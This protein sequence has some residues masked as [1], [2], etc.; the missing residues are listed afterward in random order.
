MYNEKKR[1]YLETRE[2]LR[3]YE[4]ALTI[5]NWDTETE[6]PIG[7]LEKRG[8]VI[9]VLSSMYNDL[10]F[11]EEYIDAVN[12]LYENSNESDELFKR[13]ILKVKKNLD[14]TLKLP[15]ELI[16][17]A[18]I[19][20]AKAGPAWV[21]AKV[22]NNF[23]LFEPHLTKIVDLQRRMIKYLETEE[24][25]G[26]D[27]LLD[28]YEEGMTTK[29]YDEFFNLLKKELVPLIKEISNTPY[30]H[31][32]EF[33]KKIYPVDKQKEFAKYIAS[34][35]CFDYTRGLD[36]ESEHPFTSGNS[37]FD[38]RLTNHYYEDYFI[39]SIFS[40][41]HELGHATFEQQVGEE[42]DDTLLGGCSAM[43]LHES[44]SRF[45]ENIVGR[46]YEF[47]SKHYGKL[48]EVFKEQLEDV[49][50]DTFYH[51]VNK[52]ECSLIRTEADEL[53]Y[54]LH[55]MIRYD[56]EQALLK[57]EIEVKDLPKHWNKAYK[58]Y[59]GVDVPNDKV[60]VL[61]D[62]HWAGGSFGYFPTYALGSAYS[63]QFF[64]AMKKDLNIE[65][66]FSSNNLSLVNAWL[67]EHVHKYGDSKKPEDILKDATGEE[68]NPKYYVEYLLNKYR[69]LYNL[70]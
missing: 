64:N 51:Y 62:V 31:D 37:R 41:I 4:Y 27:V 16:I 57:G 3:A 47:W 68:F 11:N 34:V 42:L 21:E 61:Q 19:V 20:T 22:T 46:S 30:K 14:S 18:S 10:V 49:S 17:E 32:L 66:A 43:A 55:I 65:E 13:E 6:A 44:Q 1:I 67:K 9:G 5:I 58:D 15:K 53:T 39:S 8:D 70:N 63:S 59:L 56:L 38:V 54:P 29:K 69:K 7:A 35:V 23:S 60:G 25:V 45:Y 26:Y 40:M 28:Q 12:Y 52:A 2:K 24:L 50:L 33:T 48:Q 36:K